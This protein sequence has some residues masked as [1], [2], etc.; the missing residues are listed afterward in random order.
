M[1]TSDQSCKMNPVDNL[2]ELGSRFPPSKAS[3]QTAALQI[4]GLQPCGNLCIGTEA[5]CP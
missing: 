5:V 3:D 1:G 2:K 4:P